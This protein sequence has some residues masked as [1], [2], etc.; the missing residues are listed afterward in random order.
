MI[1]RLGV[2]GRRDDD[3]WEDGLWLE[4]SVIVGEHAPGGIIELAL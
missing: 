4:N 1:G 2:F 3:P